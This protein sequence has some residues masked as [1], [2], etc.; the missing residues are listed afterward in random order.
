MLLEVDVAATGDLV[1]HPGKVW[2][3]VLLHLGS[4]PRRCIL[5]R[6]EAT[7]EHVLTLLEV[8][9]PLPAGRHRAL[10]QLLLLRRE[11][12]LQR[13]GVPWGLLQLGQG[14]ARRASD[15]LLQ[16][17]GPHRHVGIGRLDVR[18]GE[19]PGSGSAGGLGLSPGRHHLAPFR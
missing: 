5:R 7:V 2:V 17:I 10:Y 11:S 15:L 14:S 13:A 8:G 4:I 6:R 19:R 18:V 1:V 9:L 16:L 3:Q 12:G